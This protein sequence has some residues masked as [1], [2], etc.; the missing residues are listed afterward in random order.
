MHLFIPHLTKKRT[1]SPSAPVPQGKP[2]NPEPFPPA[3]EPLPAALGSQAAGA[4]PRRFSAACPVFATLHPLHVET[5]RGSCRVSDACCLLSRVSGPCRR[6]R[7]SEA[8]AAARLQH[9]APPPLP[10]EPAPQRPLQPRGYYRTR[11]TSAPAGCGRN[12]SEGD[13]A[14]RAGRDFPGFWVNLFPISLPERPLI[15]KL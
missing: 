14:R 11:A 13:T 9:P 7:R 8:P 15:S 12:C 10:H 5:P 2:R 3:Q 1:P 6:G 4:Q